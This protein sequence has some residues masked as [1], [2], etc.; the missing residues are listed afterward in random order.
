MSN[1]RGRLARVLAVVSLLLVGW[2]LV[3]PYIGT[4]AEPPRD[5]KRPRDKFAQTLERLQVP[6]NIP[7]SKCVCGGWNAR[8]LNDLALPSACVAATHQ[9]KH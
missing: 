9:A 1:L 3:M 5:P 6:A 8:Q 4:K 7:D 2:V